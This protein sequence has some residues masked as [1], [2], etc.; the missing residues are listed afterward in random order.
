MFGEIPTA[1]ANKHKQADILAGHH[2]FVPNPS[3]LQHNPD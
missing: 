3:C 2:A 1:A